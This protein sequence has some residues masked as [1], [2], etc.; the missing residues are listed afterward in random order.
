MALDTAN[1]LID[2][3]TAQDYIGVG[4]TVITMVENVVDAASWFCNN[5]T[6]RKLKSRT[7]TEFYDGKNRYELALHEYPIVS[8]TSIHDDPGYD[9][10]AATLIS[11]D[12]YQFWT[13]AEGREDRRV[14]FTGTVL[15]DTIKAVKVIYVAGYETIPYDIER[16]VKMLIDYW[17][18]KQLD[19]RLGVISK[20]VEDKSITYADDVP[21]D[22]LR[23]L[24]KYKKITVM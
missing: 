13:A 3:S 4:S 14:Y 7:L 12:D 10:A 23:L 6:H 20:S 9:Y 11:S 2:L 15:S 19:H 16:A 22:V 17:Y 18:R 8:I 1:S 24:Q 5:H 21:P